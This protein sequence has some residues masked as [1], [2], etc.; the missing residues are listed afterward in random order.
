MLNTEIGLL[1]LNLKVMVITDFV[2][3]TNRRLRAITVPK[4]LSLMVN[5]A[6][7]FRFYIIVLVALADLVDISI[8]FENDNFFHG[9]PP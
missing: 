7:L 5:V 8:W 4:P 3:A 2:S 9:L 1:K 6:V